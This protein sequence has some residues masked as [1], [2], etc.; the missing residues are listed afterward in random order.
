MFIDELFENLL[1]EK[2]MM[3][4]DA[5]VEVCREK[6]ASSEERNFTSVR[7]IE[8]GYQCFIKKHP[9]FNPQ[10]FRNFVKLR[11]PEL[12]EALKW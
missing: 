5:F 8:N 3:Y 10:A 11:S 1:V 9:E 2:K 12:A 7:Q 4:P 6:L